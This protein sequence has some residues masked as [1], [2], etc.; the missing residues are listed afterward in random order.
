MGGRKMERL[1]DKTQKVRWIIFDD[2]LHLDLKNKKHHYIESIAIDSDFE[3]ALFPEMNEDV[4]QN[5]FVDKETCKHLE[6]NGVQFVPGNLP[7]SKP[8]GW[9]FLSRSHNKIFWNL[10]GARG[11]AAGTMASI[12]PER[13]ARPISAPL[14]AGA[15]TSATTNPFESAS[16]FVP[17]QTSAVAAC[18][19]PPLQKV[20]ERCPPRHPP[21]PRPRR[22]GKLNLRPAITRLSAPVSNPRSKAQRLSRATRPLHPV[23]LL[24]ALQNCW[25]NRANKDLLTR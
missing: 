19:Q 4:K 22:A 7:D 10:F 12:S 16:K 21:F 25:R 14:C 3:E 5:H 13:S 15:A 11:N 6:D 18:S 23:N 1:W 2:H 8:A 9:H 24:V 20:S 17:Q